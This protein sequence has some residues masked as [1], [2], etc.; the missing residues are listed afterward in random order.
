MFFTLVPVLL[1]LVIATITFIIKVKMSP[2]EEPIIE[3]FE[4]SKDIDYTAEEA[5]KLSELNLADRPNRELV[6][7][8]DAMNSSINNAVNAGLFQVSINYPTNFDQTDQ[9]KALELQLVASGYTIE[10][11]RHYF[12]LNWK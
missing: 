4:G 10:K 3:V 9:F 6:M 11:T 12:I 5:K 2:K 1:L 7:V 8:K